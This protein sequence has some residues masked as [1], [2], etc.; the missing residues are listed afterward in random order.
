VQAVGESLSEK[1]TSSGV[2]KLVSNRDEAD[3]LLELSVS[4]AEPERFRVAVQLID[5]SGKTIW[6]NANSNRTY[7]GS[8][9]G[10]SSSISRDLLA[11][12]ESA[13]RRE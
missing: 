13:Q 2:I 9:L 11:A 8:A 12:I 7:Q 4:K 3:A 10:V 5:A 1:I 6:P